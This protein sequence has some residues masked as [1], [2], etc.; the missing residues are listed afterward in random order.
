MRG[1]IFALDIVAIIARRAVLYLPQLIHRVE[2]LDLD[3]DLV[4]LGPVVKHAVGDHHLIQV[5]LA[6]DL[7]VAEGAVRVHALASDVVLHLVLVVGPP[8][9][10]GDPDLGDRVVLALVRPDDAVPT[11]VG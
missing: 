1:P 6:R 2:A 3:I 11:E 10:V 8:V 9:V 5:L 4:A 7:R